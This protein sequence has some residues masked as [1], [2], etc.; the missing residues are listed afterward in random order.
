M[1]GNEDA[2]GNKSVLIGE[3][4]DRELVPVERLRA[5]G[6]AL[7]GEDREEITRYL[8]KT[9]NREFVDLDFRW[10]LETDIKSRAQPA[11]LAMVERATNGNFYGY[12]TS[13]K[14]DGQVS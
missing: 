13:V 12:I 2:S 1:S 8:V 3:I 14:E 11:E 7:E 6:Q 4:N 5:A 10:V 9:G